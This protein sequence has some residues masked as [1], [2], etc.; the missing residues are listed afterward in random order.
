MAAI[1]TS[2]RLVAS[3][4]YMGHSSMTII[5]DRYGPDAWYETDSVAVLDSY[6]G[7]PAGADRVSV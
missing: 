7:G 5:Y 3:Q 2:H 6:L 4:T 1:P